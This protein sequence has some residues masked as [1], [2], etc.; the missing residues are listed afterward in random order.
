M[1]VVENLTKEFNGFTALE[2]VSFRVEEG[3]TLLVLGPN[4]SGKTTLFRCIIGL[5]NFYG[6]VEIDG[7]DVKS[8]SRYVKSLIGYVPQAMGFPRGMTARQIL[9]FHLDMHGVDVDEEELLEKFGLGDVVDVEVGEFSGG[10]KQRL[11]LALAISHD[12]QILIFDE[13]M[14]NL[15][16]EGRRV[17]VKL[18]RECRARNKT[19]LVSSHKF[20]D[21]AIYMDKALV[22]NEGKCVYSGSLEELVKK[23]KATKLY[24]KIGKEAELEIDGVL[25][26]SKDWIIVETEDFLGVLRNLIYK[27]VNLKALYVEEPSLDELILKLGGGEN[28]ENA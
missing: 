13:P 15:D 10:M 12:P 28:I 2:D 8:N 24:I 19:I 26:R 22:L 3:E 1:I 20:S 16:Y 5:L 23:V 18:L 17:F 25:E 27:N 4:G 7:V 11:A 6:T 14:A 9:R 21:I